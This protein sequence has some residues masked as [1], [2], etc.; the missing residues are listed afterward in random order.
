MPQ[1]V[2]IP[3][4]V[5]LAAVSG[6]ASV[7]QGEVTRKAASRALRSQKEAQ[8]LATSRA[9][10]EQRRSEQDQRRAN[11][12]QPDLGGIL[13]REQRGSRGTSSTLL[14]GGGV[15]SSS[16][17]LGRSSLLGSA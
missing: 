7:A 4:A 8:R 12:G 13:G 6:V 1:A 14:S 5:G 9:A 2:A 16:L 3:L 17:T 11:R 15:A 10:A